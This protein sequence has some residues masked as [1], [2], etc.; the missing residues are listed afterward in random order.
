MTTTISASDQALT[1]LLSTIRQADSVELKL[2]VPMSDR[3]RGAAQLGVDPLD[4]QIRQVYFFDTPD[5]R[6]IAKGSWSARGA[7][8]G[9][10]TTPS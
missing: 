2:T 4:A 7:C 8:R 9:R 5:L 10:A 6:S 1:E 3:S